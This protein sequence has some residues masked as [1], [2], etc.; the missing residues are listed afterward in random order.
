MRNEENRSYL[1]VYLRI[2]A[3]RF[4]LIHSFSFPRLSLSN[5]VLS[6]KIPHRSACGGFLVPDGTKNGTKSLS[7]FKFYAIHPQRPS[8]RINCSII[9]LRIPQNK[10]AHSA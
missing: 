3:P 6:A 5:L 1:T 8:H 7:V 4:L 9:P 10:A 2:T